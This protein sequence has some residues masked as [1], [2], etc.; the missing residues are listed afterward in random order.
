MKILLTGASGTVGTEILKQIYHSKYSKNLSV[1]DLKSRSSVRLFSQYEDD[2]K[3]IYGNLCDKVKLEEACRNKD[4]IFHIGAVIPPLADKQPDLAEQVNVEGTRN[5]VEYIKLHSPETF[6]LY[7]SSISVYG[8]RLKDPWIKVND[9]LIP[10]IGDEYAKTKIKAESL[11]RDSGIDWSIFRLTAIM[12]MNNHK[13]SE[14]MFHMPLE[15]P[16]ELAT[17]Q[18]TARA[19]IHSLDHLDQLKHKT[20]NLGG[21]DQ[22]R[23][24]YKDLLMR[25]FNIFGL[26]KLDFPVHTFAEKNFHCGYYKDGDEL[27]EILHFREDSLETY[28]HRIKSGVKPGSKWITG[29]FK[30]MVKRKLLKKSEPLMAIKNKDPELIHRFFDK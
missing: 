25:S 4:V 29:L 23:I 2:V 12:G 9:P 20:F 3:V 17:P 8:D 6:L 30:N 14:L 19:F 5:I 13:I 21:G 28:F 18:D 1:F 15:T 16:I 24:L 10:S 22:C 11:I 26:G 7:S 27:E